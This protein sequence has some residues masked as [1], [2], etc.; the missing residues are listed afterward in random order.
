MDAVTVLTFVGMLALVAGFALVAPR[1]GVDSR[2]LA[3]HPA[4]WSA[5]AVAWDDGAWYRPAPSPAPSAGSPAP[6]PAS[7]PAPS[8]ASSPAPSPASSPAP[9]GTPSGTPSAPGSTDR[10]WGRRLG[11]L[12]AGLVLYGVS[13]AFMVR[14]RLGVMPWDVLHQ[15]LSRLV[16]LSLGTVA[17]VVGALVLLGWVPL[18]QWPG[19][20]TVSNVFVIGIAVDAVLRVLPAPS[21]IGYRVLFVVAGIGLNAVAT[22]GYIGAGLGPGPRDG[23]MTGLVRRRGWP[24]RRVRTGIEVSVVAIGWLLGGNL[25]PG[26]LLYA[27]AIGPA[28]HPLLP[29]FQVIVGARG[30]G[31]RQP[32]GAALMPDM[33]AARQA[34]MPEV[35]G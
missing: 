19:I 18:R 15:G 35:A 24:V 25:G 20:G 5:D 10:R 21:A 26:T 3:D 17:I 28:V 31:H 8:P 6:S 12:Y 14:A 11:Q 34:I 22:A 1:F 7:S 4:A 30:S 9:S 16:H 32:P 27:L 13:M 33:G 29:R 2:G 23:L